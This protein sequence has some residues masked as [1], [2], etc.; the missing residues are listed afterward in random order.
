MASDDDNEDGEVPEVG[1][2]SA[3]WM[4]KLKE[5]AVAASA[6][7]GFFGS[8]LCKALRPGLRFS[9]GEQGSLHVRSP[10]GLTIVLDRAAVFDLR[11]VLSGPG[12]YHLGSSD[13][14]LPPPL[15]AR[16]ASP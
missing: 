11:R 12:W 13:D 3:V 4:N 7:G 9:W 1:A 6:I 10:D 16:S 2:G 8:F 5:S 15:T 14:D